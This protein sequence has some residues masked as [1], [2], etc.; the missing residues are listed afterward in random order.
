MIDK[1]AKRDSCL[2][3]EKQMEAVYR[4][5]KFC[6]DKCRTYWNRENK[7]DTSKDIAPVITEPKLPPIPVEKNR[8]KKSREKAGKK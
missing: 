7:K 5:K 6:S 8:G 3:C 1:F 4:N 2:Y